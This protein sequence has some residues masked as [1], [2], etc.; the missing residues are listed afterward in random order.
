MK[1]RKYT[2]FVNY[3]SISLV[4]FEQGKL[5][6]SSEKRSKRK[7]KSYS[8]NI[9]IQLHGNRP[10]ENDSMYFSFLVM[11]EGIH[12]QTRTIFAAIDKT[13]LN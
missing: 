13:R 4:D 8:S 7:S 5:V 11:S 12:N 2:F 3:I 10:N 1:E 6:C 9:I